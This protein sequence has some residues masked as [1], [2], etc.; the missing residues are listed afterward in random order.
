MRWIGVSVVMSKPPRRKKAKRRR[1]SPKAPMVMPPVAM[2]VEVPPSRVQ[3]ATGTLRSIVRTALHDLAAHLL[4]NAMVRG[5]GLLVLGG[6]TWRYKDEIL[7]LV[8]GPHAPLE[9]GSIKKAPAALVV[10]EEAKKRENECNM[11]KGARGRN[12]RGA[13]QELVQ[14][15]Y[16]VPIGV[17]AGL[18]R[19]ADC[20]PGVRT[21]VCLS[22][23]G[24]GEGGEG[25]LGAGGEIAFKRRAARMGAVAAVPPAAKHGAARVSKVGREC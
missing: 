21:Q 16:Q 25:L 23:A 9:T 6:G 1:A 12:P 15:I 17:A 10:S 18:E 20:R 22:P 24:Q 11:E 14:R 7:R 8:L 5:I 2:P 4:K 3:R 13:A 19:D